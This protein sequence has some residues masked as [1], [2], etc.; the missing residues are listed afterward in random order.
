MIRWPPRTTRTDTLF[1]YPTLFRS[2]AEREHNLHQLAPLTVAVFEGPGSRVARGTRIDWWASA[3]RIS[4]V[5]PT[6]SANTPRSKNIALATGT[7]PTN[8][9]SASRKSTARTGQQNHQ[10]QTPARHDKQPPHT[11]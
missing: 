7:A 5:A 3:L 4:T 9:T 2:D 11:N 10:A 1:P 8:S 6:T